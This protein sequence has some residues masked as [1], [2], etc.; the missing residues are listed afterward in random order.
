ML[1]TRLLKFFTAAIIMIA[2][3]CCY[4]VD[5]SGSV[6]QLD[7]I[8]NYPIVFMQEPGKLH[9]TNWHDT[10]HI[11]NNENYVVYQLTPVRRLSDDSKISKSQTY[12]VYRIG[13][14]SGHVYTPSLRDSVTVKV[15]TLLKYYGFANAD[16]APSYLDSLHERKEFEGITIEK[17]YLKQKVEK[18]PYDSSYYYFRTGL[19]TKYSIARTQDSLH[20]NEGKKVFKVR[21]I[22][23]E[24]YSDQFKMVIPRQELYMEIQQVNTKNSKEILSLVSAYKSRN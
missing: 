16:F 1:I 4:S 5:K 13:D 24:K 9:C 8:I 6:N 3:P 17:Y 15:D 19:T 2:A 14:D 22:G 10:V 23:N 7:L 20:S 21:L 12:F 11:F 18:F